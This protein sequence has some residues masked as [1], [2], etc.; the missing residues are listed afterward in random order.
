MSKGTTQM[1]KSMSRR[2][3]LPMLLFATVP[4]LLMGQYEITSYTIDAGGSYSEGS[5]F[6]LEGTVGQHDAGPNHGMSGGDFTLFGGF[7][8]PLIVDC[9]CLGDM[10]SDGARD[11]GDIQ[12]F[13]LCIIIGG[14]CSCADVNGMSG[15]GLDDIPEFVNNLVTGDGC[16]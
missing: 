5:D 1:K 2:A 8:T 7:W 16:P 4:S 3:W 10:N 12:Q 11:G 6:E 13:V 15:I 14:A 9:N